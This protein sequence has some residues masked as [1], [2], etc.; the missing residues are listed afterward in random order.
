MVSEHV[1]ERACLGQVAEGRRRAVRVDVADVGGRQAGAPQGGADHLAH[2]HR[3]GV[4][5]RDVVCVVRGAVAEHLGVHPG[6]ARLGS[7]HVLEHEHAGALTDHE[8][9]A[10]RVERP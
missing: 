1:L 2:P 8:A 9:R 10:R 6:A 7:L 5:L 4:G 3:L